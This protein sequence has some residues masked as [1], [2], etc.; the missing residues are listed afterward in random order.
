MFSLVGRCHGDRGSQKKIRVPEAASICSCRVSSRPWSQVSVCADGRWELEQPGGEGVAHHRCGVAVGEMDQHD[1]AT[2]PFDERADRGV[3]VG[4]DDQ[5]AFPVADDATLV[6][7]DG[8]LVEQSHV[9]DLVLR[10]HAATLRLAAL[11]AGAQLAGDRTEDTG[12]QGLIDR[13]RAGPHRRIVR[14]RP[15][16]EARDLCAVTISGAACR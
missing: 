3:H 15:L 10:R 4:A 12:E 1:V 13:L 8:P 9:G 7:L 5:I 11:A 14:E 16:Q 2:D 6:H